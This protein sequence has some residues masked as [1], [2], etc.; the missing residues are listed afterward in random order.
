MPWQVLVVGAEIAI[1][2]ELTRADADIE[3]TTAPDVIDALVLTHAQR[4]D[5]AICE[6]DRSTEDAIT[7]VRAM[8]GES[9]TTHLPIVAL[10]DD[11]EPPARDELL[12][13]GADDCL[14]TSMAPE[15]VIAA[16]AAAIAKRPAHQLAQQMTDTLATSEVRRPRRAAKDGDIGD[17]RLA[18]VKE[19]AVRAL[20][21]AAHLRRQL[22]FASA[23]QAK[24]VED[25]GEVERQLR[26][27]IAELEA[28][29]AV[30]KQA[31]QELRLEVDRTVDLRESARRLYN[32]VLDRAR[33]RYREPS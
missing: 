33:D 25:A 24:L 32:G 17:L 15:I 4:F 6:Y 12:D 9:A 5:A 14:P 29:V 11:L 19:Q 18:A 3:V 27:R 7:F 21:D 13:A 8:R 10:A 26:A 20:M 28:E 2:A 23:A 16:L 22:E 30:H 1:G 31:A